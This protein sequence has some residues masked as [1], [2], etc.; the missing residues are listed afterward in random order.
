MAEFVNTA[1][2]KINDLLD[3]NPNINEPVLK[4]ADKLKVDRPVVVLGAALLP[5]FLLLIWGNGNFAV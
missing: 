2:N 4:I 1:K 3:A 5:F